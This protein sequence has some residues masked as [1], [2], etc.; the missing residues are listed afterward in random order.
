MTKPDC[1]FTMVGGQ[2]SLRKKD[3]Q[4][5]WTMNPPNV[6]PCTV[7]ARADGDLEVVGVGNDGSV[8]IKAKSD[9]ATGAF[10][11]TKTCPECG[12]TTLGTHICTYERPWYKKLINLVWILLG[13][14]GA[15]V[16]FF[17][18]GGIGALIGFLVGMGIT[19]VFILLGM[20]TEPC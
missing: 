3:D 20:I 6:H 16:G 19:L 10:Y 9:N 5:R 7:S 15:I 11:V 14:A 1:V 2:S 13:I 4:T 18:G 8:G 12:P 17:V